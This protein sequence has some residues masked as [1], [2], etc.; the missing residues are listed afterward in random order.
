MGKYLFTHFM[1]SGRKAIFSQI[2]ESSV[3]H[4]WQNKTDKLECDP[5]KLKTFGR[6]IG[7][8]FF[9]LLLNFFGRFGA[10]IECE[11][12]IQYC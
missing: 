3:E 2:Q 8:R 11:N 10:I 5:L 4:I 12:T 9:D 7:F 1:K 6:Q